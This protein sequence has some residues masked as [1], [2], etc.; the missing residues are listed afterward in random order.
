[1]K[2]IKIFVGIILPFLLCSIACQGTKHIVSQE[3]RLILEKFWEYAKNQKLKQLS[4]QE[5]IPII[6][7]FF[8]GTPYQG[9]TLNVNQEEKLV[10]NLR[11]LD[12]VTFVENVMA[13]ATLPDFQP[14]YEVQFTENLRKI[15][16]R[17]G[18][19][20]DYSSRLHYSS[21]WLYDLH[22]RQLIHDVTAQ[23]GGIPFQ[24]NVYF[25]SEHH[26][27]YPQLQNDASMVKKIR[28]VEAAINK[29]SMYYIPK[30]QVAQAY[31]KI[32]QGD[33]L[34]ITTNLKGLD[35][36]HLG[37]AYKKGG[38][39]YLLHASSTAKMVVVSAQPLKEYMAGIRSQTGIMVGRVVSFSD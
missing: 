6:A 35:T 39:V 32:E 34:L 5:R 25:M 27:R 7:T 9:N 31:D 20:E 18:E 4:V 26:E 36:S 10:I 38:I 19:I 22:Q 21:D 2:R 23:V 1:M 30:M 16:Y 8:I 12:C 24:P 28:Q 37:F 17:K 13:L 15:R 11:A 33:V 29:R 14:S 3:D